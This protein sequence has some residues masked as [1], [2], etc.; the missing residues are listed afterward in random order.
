MSLQGPGCCLLATACRC[1]R[2]QHGED[3][4]TRVGDVT[5]HGLAWE[6]GLQKLTWIGMGKESDGAGKTKK[7]GTWVLVT[8][9][10]SRKERKTFV[11]VRWSR[12]GKERAA[13]EVLS[14]ASWFE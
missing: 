5:E 1:D 3:T 7:L 9:A 4:A 14:M 2:Q 6:R 12:L 8:A 11:V 10:F 13:R